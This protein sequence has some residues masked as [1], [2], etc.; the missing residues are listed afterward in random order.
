MD[1]LIEDL[2]RDWWLFL[3]RGIAA[4]LFGI[5]AFV[6]P[7]LTL[8][9][10][11]IMFGAYV[12]VDGAFGLFYAI[13][14]RKQLDYWW[15]W[16]I[17]GVLGIIVGVLTFVMPGITALVLLMFIAAW[18]IV[19][20]A[21]RIITAFRLR[22]EI[23]GEWLLIAGGALS[24]LF[25]VLLVAVPQAGILSVIWLIG[26]YAVLFG[27]LFVGLAFR[28]RRSGREDAHA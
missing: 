6:W 26:F 20:G 23:R 11:V 13:R 3:V 9:V 8:A 19:G 21:L 14:G 17:E 16:A 12:L 24:I 15:L 1:E 28:L 18:A 4:I 10:L 25:G 7:G 27:V 5:A 2:R 22:K